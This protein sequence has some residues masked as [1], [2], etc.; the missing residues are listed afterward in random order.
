[1]PPKIRSTPRLI[2]TFGK[3]ATDINRYLL[4]ILQHGHVYSMCLRPCTTT[5]NNSKNEK[6]GVSASF[7]LFKSAHSEIQA[8]TFHFSSRMLEIV[9]LVWGVQCLPALTTKLSNPNQHAAMKFTVQSYRSLFH[10]RGSWYDTPGIYSTHSKSV[11]DLDIRGTYNL[12]LISRSS[13]SPQTRVKPRE[14]ALQ[15]SHRQ[16][17]TRQCPHVVIKICTQMRMRLEKKERNEQ[18]A[19]KGLIQVRWG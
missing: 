5:P 10:L 12:W 18:Q 15:Q 17:A 13:G 4:E 6:T 11:L 14:L 16:W 8:N 7:H 9:V 1:M 19:S 2:P 3:F